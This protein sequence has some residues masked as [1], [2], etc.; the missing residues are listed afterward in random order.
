MLQREIFFRSARQLGSMLRRREISS[1]ELT[2]GYLDRLHTIGP[3]L[4]AVVTVCEKRALEEAQQADREL[5]AG[6]RR[7]ALHGVPYG[8]KDLVATRDAPTTWGA[9][10]YREQRFE[11]DATVVQR[12][13]E[14]GAVLLAKLS[15]VE[16]AGGMGYDEADASFTGPGRTPWNPAF[17]SGGSSSG[18]GSAVAAG[19]VG[20]AI[21]SETSGS[22]LTPCAF[23]GVSGLRPTYGL[24]PRTGAMALSWTLDK[25]G[26]MC[27]T[28]DDCGL[29]LQAIAGHD[30][31][32]PTSLHE[33]FRWKGET[34][35]GRPLGV[36]VPKG[37]LEAVQPAVRDNFEATLQALGD[38]IVIEREVPWPEFPWGPAVATIVNAEGAAAFL[39]LLESGDAAKLRCPADKIGGYS[40]L[41]TYAVDY[42]QALRVRA[43]MQRALNELF[44]KFD[45]VLSPTRASVAPPTNVKFRDA[46]PGVRGGPPLIPA[47][48][49]CGLPAVCVPN[50]FG[51]NGLPTSFAAMGPALSEA[52]LIEIAAAFQQ[53]TDWHRQTPPVD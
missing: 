1:V 4:N 44:R 28:A 31:A 17:W 24:V 35:R 38:R 32:D 52:S 29:V 12:L 46:Y 51:E 37:C 11:G 6:R 36:A 27:R 47:G 20:F 34:D 3:Q 9:E 50:G 49:L 19:L 33:G 2:R 43:P 48:N 26:P 8:L 42:I 23:S 13:G 39:P 22:I 16:L 40:G 53:A 14:A 30:A 41:V 5:R 45:V 18:P 21:G 7:G 15:M 10:P 25:L